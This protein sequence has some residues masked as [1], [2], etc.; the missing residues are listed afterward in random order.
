M[1]DSRL[2]YHRCGIEGVTCYDVALDGAIIG[3]VWTLSEDGRRWLA[4]IPGTKCLDLLASRGEAGLW[5]EKT[6]RAI[7]PS[8]K[9]TLAQRM[10]AKRERQKYLE[11]T[12]P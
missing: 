4:R 6:H 9:P 11:M 7:V 1:G 10:K 5:C 2:S 12:T 8:E 3:R